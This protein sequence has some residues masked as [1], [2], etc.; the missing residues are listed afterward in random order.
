MPDVASA[1]T[2]AMELVETA[3]GA[4]AEFVALPEYCGGL[5]SV[6]G[7]YAP[8]TFPEVS[9]PVLA[10]LR[11]ACAKNSVWMLIG[12]IAVDGPRGKIKNRSYLIDRFGNIQS[13]Y[14]K[15]HLFDVRLSDEEVYQESAV[16]EGGNEAVLTDTPAG[17]IG[18]TICYDL[19]FPNLYRDLAQGGA[20]VLTVPA[21]FTKKTGEAHW[22]VLNRARAVENG[23]FVIAPCAIGPIPGGGESYGHSLI[24][25]PWGKV[26]ADGGTLPGVVQAKIDLDEVAQARAKIPSLTHDRKFTQSSG[27]VRSV[28]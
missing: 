22:H 4:G 19:R 18:Q 6:D 17:R 16:V 14:D 25:D 8:P 9:H 3:V 12:S 23:A 26:I 13:R 28:A 21:A 5:K 20:E 11:E 1:V 15:V 7:L 24:V 10:A 27:T 2:E